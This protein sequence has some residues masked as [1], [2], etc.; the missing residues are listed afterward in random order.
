MHA[1]VRDSLVA[2]HSLTGCD[3]VSQFCGMGKKTAW[4]IFL[5]HPELLTTLGNGDLTEVISAEV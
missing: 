1:E 3:T 2:F 5:Q 4:K